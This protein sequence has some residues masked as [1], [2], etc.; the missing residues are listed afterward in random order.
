MPELFYSPEEL[1]IELTPQRK[2][3]KVVFTNGCFDILHP[4]HIKVLSDAAAL[5][6][7]LIVGLNSDSSVRKLKG[8]LRPV[9]P[10]QDRAALLLAVK[11][12]NY[13]IVFDDETPLNLI[14]SLKPDYLV[15]GSEYALGDIVG[16]E[17]VKNTVRIIMEPGYSTSSIIRKIRENE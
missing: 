5:G 15:K 2:T 3:K 14:R 8:S 4:G 7:I 13:V 11:Y 16:E 17:Y 10:E 6:D 12:V 9:M 1:L